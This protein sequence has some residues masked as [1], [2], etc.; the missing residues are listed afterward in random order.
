MR[1]SRNSLA[2]SCI[3][4]IVASCLLTPNAIAALDSE[5]VS[6]LALR[7]Q[8][9]YSDTTLLTASLTS[10]WIDHLSRHERQIADLRISRR[11]GADEWTS[12]YQVQF[13][14][15]GIPG[16]EHRFWQQYRHVFALRDSSSSLE[17][18]VRLE[19][20]Y[21]TNLERLGGRLRITGR[22]N[23]PLGERDTL[24]L[25]YEWVGN[26]K[27]VSNGIRKGIS[28]DRLIT[29]LQHD[30]NNGHRLDLEYQLRYQHTAFG[31]NAI[32]HQ[33]QLTYLYRL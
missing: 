18:A 6:N 14:R 20:R 16:M 19:E 10:R 5:T 22:W 25:G 12:A 21:F 23:K 32:Q 17:S 4:T 8:K 3:A 2:L 13:A 26:L 31:A 29:T 33:L 15:L 30:L 24:R 9:R 27:T 28:Q 1:G 7:F 11:F